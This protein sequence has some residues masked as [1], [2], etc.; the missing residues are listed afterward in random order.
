ML[1]KEPNGNC[2]M[3]WDLPDLS[4]GFDLRI[5][6]RARKKTFCTF[7][8]RS[9]W[10]SLKQGWEYRGIFVWKKNPGNSNSEGNQKHFGL[11]GNS[12]YRGKLQWNLDQGNLVRVSG[13]FE[14]S[15]FEL[16]S[17]YC[18][19]IRLIIKLRKGWT[20]ENFQECLLRSDQSQ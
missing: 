7:K 18:S 2:F 1:V 9:P 8:K 16:S 20:P 13:E 15:E 19:S 11:A 5:L 17:I 12:S 3:G 4:L 10:S 6:L 14:L